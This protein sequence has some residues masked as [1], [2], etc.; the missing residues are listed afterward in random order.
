MKCGYP[1]PCPWHTIVVDASATPPTITEPATAHIGLLARERLRDVA[2]VLTQGPALT[3]PEPP[4]APSR[5]VR[6]RTRRLSTQS[7]VERLQ[8][9][10]ARERENTEDSMNNSS[11]DRPIAYVATAEHAGKEATDALVGACERAGW[12]AVRAEEQSGEE[13]ELASR[14]RGLEEAELCVL[15]L[16]TTPLDP[17]VT[18]ALGFAIA[19]G[20]MAIALNNPNT[21]EP[22]PPVFD[23][24]VYSVSTVAMVE[25]SLASLLR[26]H[27]H[28]K[29]RP[30]CA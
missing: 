1:L 3:T 12:R 16:D 10:R 30:A 4:K 5:K 11:D 17:H 6:Q 23:L 19:R 2:V 18:F 7:D 29:E 15:A 24:C 14:L 28:V 8:A 25:H 20:K 27:A 13:D 26:M 22:L 21:H 9:A